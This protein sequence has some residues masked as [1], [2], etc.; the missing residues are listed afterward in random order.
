VSKPDVLPYLPP[1]QG[2]VQLAVGSADV[3]PYRPAVQSVQVAAPAREYLPA[4]HITAVALTDAT[5]H[6]Y[7]ALQLPV[8]PVVARPDV[9]PYRP[10]AQSTHTLAP[11]RE[12]L[13]AGQ[14]AAVA[15][16]DPATQ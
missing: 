16:V 14:I 10:A 3:A 15:L 4:G 1:G 6:T 8:H 12:Y 11:V 9:D 13:P 7:P 2:A 5:G